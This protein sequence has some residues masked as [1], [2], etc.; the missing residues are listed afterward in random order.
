MSKDRAN[1]CRMSRKGIR[2][3]KSDRRKRVLFSQHGGVHSEVMLESVPETMELLGGGVLDMKA[4]AEPGIDERK[5]SR[6]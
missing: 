4:P 1:M 6:A 5:S 2:T 3:P